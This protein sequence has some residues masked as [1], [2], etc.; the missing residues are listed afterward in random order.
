MQNKSASIMKK[1]DYPSK[2]EKVDWTKNLRDNV[3]TPRQ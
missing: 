1:K 3:V 2:D